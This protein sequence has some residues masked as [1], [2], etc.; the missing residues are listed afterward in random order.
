[1]YSISALGFYSNTLRI[2]VG[3]KQILLESIQKV[4]FSYLSK[5][6]DQKEKLKNTSKLI[7]EIFILLISPLLIGI[8]VTS[9]ALVRIVFGDLW[10][11]MIPI[12]QVLCI[13]GLII[14]LHHINLTTLTVVGRTDA[15]LRIEII[16]KLI[17]VSIFFYQLFLK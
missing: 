4:S 13:S 10:L 6:Q 17:L 8:E 16:K 12:I 14:P 2:R 7:S 1:M 9:D 15:Y 5:F 11:G 3:I